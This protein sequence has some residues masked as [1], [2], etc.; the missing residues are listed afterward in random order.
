M[1]SPFRAQPTLLGPPPEHQHKCIS[2]CRVALVSTGL[3][4]GGKER[5]IVE[6]VRKCDR[7]KLDM[8]VICLGSAGHLSNELAQLGCE[9]DLL[10]RPE[11]FLPSLV[12]RLFRMFRDHQ[13]EV[14]HTHDD[15]SAVYALPAAA[16]AGIGPRIHTQHHSQIVYGR[17]LPIHLGALAARLSSTFVCVSQ[18]GAD[19]MRQAGISA[20]GLQ[21]IENGVDLDRFSF[22]GP[23]PSGP[24]LAVARL[25]A[26]KGIEDLLLAA[27]RVVKAAPDFHLNIAGGG[28]NLPELVQLCRSLGL[29]GRISF[30]GNRSD[31]PELLAASRLFVLPSKT[32]GLSLSLLEAMARGVP[33]VATRVGGTPEA[34][35]DG[36]SG[37][38]VEAGDPIAL[39]EAIVRLWSGP[40][41]ALALCRTARSQVEHR[42]NIERT[43]AE[44]ERLYLART[45]SIVAARNEP[46]SGDPLGLGSHGEDIQR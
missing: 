32:E 13:I 43:I 2:A 12:W 3:D 9:V 26:E 36:E 38:L 30:L 31:V 34:I 8:R 21:V 40:E 42:F 15:R 4:T 41:L 5:V 39:A 29:G 18:H 45:R 46:E 24:A 20:G 25:S 6:L 17:L 10:E 27:A 33:I 22:R 16:M 35:V 1:G 37:L 28:P 14:V 7:E 11:G 23:N 44:Y 19:L